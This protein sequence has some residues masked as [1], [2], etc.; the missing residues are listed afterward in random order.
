MRISR[1]QIENFRNFKFLDVNLGQNII[2]VGE[3]KSGKSN[4][5]DA[6]RLVLDPSLSDNDRRLEA[7]D[8]WDGDGEAPFDGRD[9]RISIQFTNFADSENLDQLPLSWLSDCLIE[10]VPQKIA[11]ITYLYFNDGEN[12]TPI[13]DDYNFKIYPG[14]K[15]DEQFDY[16]GMQKSIPLQLIEALR[17]IASDA[18]VW[19]KSPLKKL[20]DLSDISADELQPFAD[21][22]KVISDE[23]LQIP[24]IMAIENDINMRTNGMIGNLYQ[25]DTEL[26]LNATTPQAILET[27]RLYAEGEKHRSLNQISLGMQNVL[28]LALLSLLLEKKQIRVNKRKEPFLPMMALEEPEAHLHPHLQRLVFK[29]FLALAETRKQPVIITTH[30]P[31]LAS[32]ASLNDLVLLRQSNNGSIAVSAYDFT[33]TLESRAKK[34]LERFLDITKSEMLFSKGVIFV[35]G[36]VEILL[37]SEFANI[38]GRPL[39][40]FGIS[41]CNVYGAEFRHVVTLAHKFQIPFVVLTDGD[42][43]RQVKGLQR[44]IDLIEI[45]SLRIKQK[46]QILYDQGHKNKVSRYLTMLGIFVNDWTLEPTLIDAGLSNELKNTFTEL[47]DELG[48]KVRAGAKYIDDFLAFPDDTKMEK[49]LG[50]ISDTRWGKGRFAQRLVVHIIE[51]SQTLDTQDKK[52]RIV[53]QYIKDAIIFLTN[54]VSKN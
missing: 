21:R 40:K 7:S 4:F 6:L 26:G 53:P 17:D 14:N 31:H 5:V 54:K 28:Y 13:A 8:F 49:I 22:I 51:K 38:L 15:K 29:D 23:I 52:N 16:K 30:S 39:D 1:I 11:Q 43:Y 9:I 50:A 19:H 12:D 18:R 32:S 37:V 24:S 27:L 34:D 10:I 47:G 46:L 45:I 42:K 20:L 35:E 44:A 2:L 33:K 3:N 25:I 41:I 48:E 36:D